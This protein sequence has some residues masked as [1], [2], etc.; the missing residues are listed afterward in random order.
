MYKKKSGGILPGL[1][2]DAH[3]IHERGAMIDLHQQLRGVQSLEALLGD[4]QHLPDDRRSIVHLLEPPRRIG[5]QPQ[6]G[7]GR[8]DRIARAQVHPVLLGKL[9]EREHPFPVSIEYLGGRFQ[10]LLL[11]PA[12][13]A[14]LPLLCPLLCRGIWDRGQRGD[15]LMAVGHPALALVWVGS[16]WR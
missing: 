3:A 6:G 4:Q 1:F 10:P 12:L 9:V 2:H 16:L 5:P 7:K 11:A 14:R 15:H 8:F 13:I